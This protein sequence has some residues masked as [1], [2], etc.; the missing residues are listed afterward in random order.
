MM[1]IINTY[2]IGND[3]HDVIILNFLCYISGTGK[4]T[5]QQE[6]KNCWKSRYYP[7]FTGGEKSVV[8]DEANQL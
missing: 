1:C 3:V 8:K 4:S 6:T 5:K 2:M 7:R